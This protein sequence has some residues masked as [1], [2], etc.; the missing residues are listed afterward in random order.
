MGIFSWG[1]D[2]HGRGE[3]NRN[4]DTTGRAG[5]GPN[6]T[7]SI[8]GLMGWGR[9]PTGPSGR[10]PRSSSRTGG[11]NTGPPRGRRR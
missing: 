4:E 2:K 7:G 11:R 3:G 1:G 8:L 9:G 10:A 6:R 5:R